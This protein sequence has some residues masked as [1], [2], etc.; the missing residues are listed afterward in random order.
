MD[1]IYTFITMIV[2]IL[3]IVYSFNETYKY[4]IE[5]ISYIS[6]YVLKSCEYI[7]KTE[8]QKLVEWGRDIINEL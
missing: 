8:C 1:R 3:A 5:R 2:I 7:D 4:K 6:G